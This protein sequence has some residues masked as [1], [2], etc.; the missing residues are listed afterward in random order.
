MTARQR[1][2]LARETVEGLMSGRPDLVIEVSP[3]SRA[4]DRG[5]KLDLYLRA[6]VPEYVTISI[7]DRRI[8]WRVLTQ[9]E[10]RVMAPGDDGVYRSKMFPGLWIDETASWNGDD[11]RLR[12]VMNQG[13]ASLEYRRFAGSF[14]SAR[15]DSGRNP[16]APVS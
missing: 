11:S 8:A 14:D 12:E 9:G 2:G 5:S 3:A 7:K 4:Y 13:L 15:M 1:G 10:Y 16:H 6:G